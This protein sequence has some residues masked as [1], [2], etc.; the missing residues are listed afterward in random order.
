MLERIVWER[1]AF[2]ILV[3]DGANAFVGKV[4]KQLA[5]LLRIE[6]IETFHYPQGNSTTERHH[7]L[8]GEF[9]RMLPVHKRETWDE[10]VGAVAY[11]SNMSTN[12]STGFSPFELDCGYQPSSSA[13]L[14]FQDKPVPL[15]DTQMFYKTTQEQKDW[16][17]RV[18]SLHELANRYNSA[19]K[20]ITKE[21]LNRPSGPMT[22]FKAGEDVIFYVPV[23]PKPNSEKDDQTDGKQSTCSTGVEDQLSRGCQRQPIW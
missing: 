4:A 23:Q 12:T 10:E 17:K 18:Q 1:G 7:V 11:A 21:R 9:L 20:E 22:T 16:L 13:D 6:K 5:S 15:L 14:V 3:S 8:L 2:G 19:Q